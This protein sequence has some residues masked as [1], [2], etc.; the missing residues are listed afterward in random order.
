MKILDA[1]AD[2][3]GGAIDQ[4]MGIVG[5]PI[6][7]LKGVYDNSAIKAIM[8]DPANFQQYLMELEKQGKS[9]DASMPPVPS[10]YQD[11]PGAPTGGFMRDMPNYMNT[12]QRILAGGY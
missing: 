10:F 3:V 4:T 5:D 9:I 1:I 7:H 6:G 11:V 12:S 8:Q 2:G